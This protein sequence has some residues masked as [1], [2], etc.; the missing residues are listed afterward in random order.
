MGCKKTAHFFI[1]KNNKLF[2]TLQDFC[3]QLEIPLHIKHTDLAKII[4]ETRCE[5]NPCALCARMRRQGRAEA[6]R[7]VQPAE[8]IAAAVEVQNDTV[9]ALVPGQHP[10]AGELFEVVVVGMDLIPAA[11]FHQ[12]ADGVLS[13]AD[14]L[15]GAAA[16]QGLHHIQLCAYSFCGY[17]HNHFL[18][19]WFSLSYHFRPRGRKLFLGNPSTGGRIPSP[20]E[21][22]GPFPGGH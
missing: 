18:I 17:G 11:Q 14:G 6:R 3:K 12:F 19:N 15:Q 13:L 9:A 20:P 2:Y 16:Q 5:S 8:G 10:G 21:K 4:F 7:I 1:S 22:K